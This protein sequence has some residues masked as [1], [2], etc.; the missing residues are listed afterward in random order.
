L[1]NN[2]RGSTAKDIIFDM[3]LYF[4]CICVLIIVAYPLYFII[5]ASFSNP[6]EVAN[7]NVWLLPKG[8]T[9]DGYKE[10]FRHKEIWVGYRNTIFYTIIGT[11][12]NLAVNVPAA[13]ALSRKDLKGRNI[14]TFYFVFTMFFSG[15][16]IPT[17][18]TIKNFRLY[19]TFW[20]M[21]L[22]FSVAVYHMII[23]RTFFSTNIPEELLEA[24]QLDGCSNLRFFFQIVLPLSKAI[25]A[26]IALYSAVG[27]WNSYFNALI[28]IKSEGL[29]PLQLVLRNILITNE[30]MAG[31][32]D[33]LAAIEARRLAALMKYAIIIISTAPIMCMYPLIQKY[34]S[35]GVMIGAIKG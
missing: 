9:L 19:D 7:G 2:F 12:F 29:K 4:I 3:I 35:Q 6:S 31:T 17:F 27:H 25:L 16:L 21:V 32:G 11:L 18:F 33:G 24:S 13:Y 15:G 34:F 28:Y 20:V 30:A 26:V 1:N 8:Y 23:A 5:I 14:F 10:L 22:P